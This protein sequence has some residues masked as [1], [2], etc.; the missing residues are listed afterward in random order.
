MSNAPITLLL[1]AARGGDAAATESLFNAVYAELRT[2]A[3]S[4]RRRWRGNQTMNTT[5]LIHEVYIR[6]AG[7]EVPDFANRTHFFATASKAMRQVLVNYAEKQNTAKR[8][9]DAMRITFDETVFSTQASAE[10]LLFLHQLLTDLESENPRRC[11]IIECR[12]FGGMTIEEVAEAMA[13]SPATVKREW[14]L[15]TAILYRMMQ[16]NEGGEPKSGEDL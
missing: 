7:N 4:N 11:E 2:L 15:G 13:I 3:S 9:G 5:A 6:L 1:D 12:V 8:G 14:K 16:G 10:E